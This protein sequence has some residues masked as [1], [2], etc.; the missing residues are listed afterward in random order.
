MRNQN[1]YAMDRRLVIQRIAMGTTALV[2][3]PGLIS[4][5]EKAK[6]EPLDPQAKGPQIN[7]DL[8]I[9][10]S[11]PANAAL[12]SQGGSKVINGI[13]VI[14]LGTSGFTA[15]ASA[16]THEGTQVTYSA[17]SN[18]LQCSS[19]GSVF[20]M[21]GSVLNGPAVLPLKKYFVSKNGNLLTVRE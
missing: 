4:G 12:N 2:L 15:L 8:T 10:L 21:T 11:L 18:N 19:H 17:K 20:S 14:N 13:I 7:N 9:D 3:V 6:Y 1:S 5:C 16:C